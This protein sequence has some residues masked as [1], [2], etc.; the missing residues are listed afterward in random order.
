MLS[1]DSSALVVFI[2]VWVL[3][4]ILTKVFFNPVRKVRDERERRVRQGLADSRR[5]QEEYEQSLAK[6]DQVIRDAKLQ[7]DQ[8]R[9][10]LAAEASREKNRLLAEM[11]AES[12]R[13]LDKAKSEV[14]A[15]VEALKKEIASRA[16][17][18]AKDIEGRLLD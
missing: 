1:I 17:D 7:A 3:V 16:E 8:M 12:R 15:Q 9:D 4:L 14:A 10:E 5:S 11:N 2:I 13:R 18:L 6:V